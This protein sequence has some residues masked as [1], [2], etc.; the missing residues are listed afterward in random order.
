MARDKQ[1]PPHPVL[2]LLDEFAALGY[3]E[4]IET[5]MGLMRCYG[6]KLWLILQDLPQLQGLYAKKWESFIANS[7]AIQAFGVNDRETASY[8]SD[9][10]G[11][12]TIVVSSQTEKQ[13]WDEH[14]SRNIN[15]TGRG[16]ILPDEIMRMGDDEQLLFVQGQNP[17][18]IKKIRYYLEGL[19]KK[20]ADRTPYL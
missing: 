14:N 10:A 18:R 5:A 19:F 9:L 1:K 3:L 7:G 2:F 8:L 15:T 20:K 13:K 6:V 12:R 4:S 17:M 16:L 11:K